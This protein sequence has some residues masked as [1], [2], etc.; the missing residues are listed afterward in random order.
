MILPMKKKCFSVE[1]MIRVLKQARDRV[2][3]DLK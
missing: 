1:Q 2:G 3:L